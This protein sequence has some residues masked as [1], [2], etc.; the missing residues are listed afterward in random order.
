MRYDI[1][2]VKSGENLELRFENFQFL[3]VNGIDL[4]NAENR[5]QMGPLLAQ[6][7][8]MGSAIPSLSINSNGGVEDVIGVEKTM[9]QVI[10]MYPQSDPQKAAAIAKAMRSPT[11]LAAVKEKSKD[12]WRIWVGRGWTS[13]FHRDKFG[14]STLRLKRQQAPSITD[15]TAP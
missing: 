8:A 7:T 15:E 6:I 11:T 2:L 3:D 1:V 12:F 4:T 10:K 5:K 9:D 13:I 14:R